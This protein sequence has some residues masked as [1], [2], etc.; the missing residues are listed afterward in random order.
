MEKDQQSDHKPLVAPSP[1]VE[2]LEQ[3]VDV[4]RRSI[5][6]D[7]TAE[8]QRKLKVAEQLASTLQQTVEELQALHETDN[9]AVSRE[10]IAALRGDHLEVVAWREK[11]RQ[12][13]AEEASAESSE[14]P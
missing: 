3:V 8:E 7:A 2:V 12:E 4:D 13:L 11:Q 6:Y 5:S 9:S 10:D 14:E 1:L